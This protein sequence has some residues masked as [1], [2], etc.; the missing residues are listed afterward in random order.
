MPSGFLTWI[1]RRQGRLLLPLVAVNLPVLLVL[2]FGLLWLSQ[3][4]TTQIDA[5]GQALLQESRLLASGLLEG[6]TAS[7]SRLVLAQER[8]LRYVEADGEVQLLLYERSGALAFDS[9]SLLV[10][11]RKLP[12]SPRG[13]QALWRRIAEPARQALPRYSNSLAASQDRIESLSLSS[14]ETPSGLNLTPSDEEG[15]FFA[16]V[17]TPGERLLIS[18]FVPLSQLGQPLSLLVITRPAEAVDAVMRQTQRRIVA[19]LLTTW[20][21]TLLVSFW[22][23]RMIIRP[24]RRLAQTAEQLQEGRQLRLHAPDV[25]GLDDPQP[26]NHKDEISRLRRALGGLVERLRVRAQAADHFAAEVT[27]EIKNPLTS[28]RSA[29]E[30]LQLVQDSDKRDKLLAIIL[31]DIDRLDKLLSD[32]SQA[33]RLD[34]ELAATPLVRV[35]LAHLLRGL[36]ESQSLVQ[37][38]RKEAKLLLHLD[39]QAELLVWGLE[40]RWGQVFDNLLANARSFTPADKQIQIHAWQEGAR[41]RIRMD[42]EGR[43]LPADKLETVFQRFFTDRDGPRQGEHSG[44]GLALARQIVEASGGRIWADNH[45]HADG[46]LAGARFEIDIAAAR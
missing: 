10:G 13:A 40:S 43:G 8:A 29:T 1:G 34:A 5:R 35:D 46:S 44:L 33:S 17:E 39:P 19:L 28:L 7:A 9:E 30:T 45:A 41:V 18:A 31:Q 11:L 25:V 16:W 32:I 22:L 4:W 42:D 14:L 6:E 20:L 26:L 38:S 24:L 21:L 36:A 2:L 12:P 27:H 37:D 15:A 3:T 23:F